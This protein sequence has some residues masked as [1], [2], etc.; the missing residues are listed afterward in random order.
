MVN[1]T[2]PAVNSERVAQL[3]K[4]AKRAS[5]LDDLQLYLMGAPGALS[6]MI[7]GYLPL[8]GLILA[9]KDYKIPFGFLGSPW[10]GLSNF[11]SIVN[12]DSPYG[13][14]AVRNTLGYNILFILLDTFLSIVL[15]L[16]L[17]EMHFKRL[18]KVVQTIYILPYFLAITTVAMVVFCFLSPTAGSLTSVFKSLHEV[19][20]NIVVPDFYSEDK[21]WPWFLIIINAW[22]CVGYNAIVYLASISGFNK[23]YYEAAMLDGATKWQQTKYITLPQLS[24]MISILLIMSTSSIF[25]GDMGMFYSVPRQDQN[26]TLYKSTLVLDT[27]AYFSLS[28]NTYGSGVAINFLQGIVGLLFMLTSN[29]IVTL[30]EPDNA[31]F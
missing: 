22:K 14:I 8:Y 16:L 6:T 26:L 17:N 19:N 11:S 28:N 24:T 27:Y 23:E 1:E 30:I 7:F 21:W 29:K 5:F 15:A 31:L 25:S 4:K 12:P 13:L 10:V 3:A 2:Q 18:A 20:P 9:F